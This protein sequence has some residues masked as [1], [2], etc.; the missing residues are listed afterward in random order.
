[1]TGSNL[2]MKQIL[3]SLRNGGVE[4]LDVPLPACTPDKLV[5]RTQASLI[6][7]GTERMLLDFGNSSYLQM[8][9]EHPDRVRQVVDKIVTDGLLPTYEAVTRKLDE[10]LPL[11]YCSAGTVVE[12]GSEIEEFRPGDRVVTNSPHGEYGMV[13]RNLCAAI[14][15]GVPAEHACFAPLGA[16][17]LQ[18]IRLASPTFG[19]KFVVF[20]SGLVGLLTAQLLRANGCEVM[21]VD[22]RDDRLELARGYGADTINSSQ[23]DPERG[24]VAW[25]GGAGADGVIIAASAKDDSILHQ[26]AL[27]CRKRARIVLVGVVDLN[28]RRSD[29]YE[30]ELQFQV[31][32]SYG[33]G[34]YDEKYESGGLDYPLEYVRWTEQRN[35]DAILTALKLR[36]L[37]VSKLVTHRFEFEEAEGAYAKLAEDN[38][39][40]G[41]VLNYA[42]SDDEESSPPV[43]R[44]VRPANDNLRIGMVGAGGFA[45]G[46]L[47]PLLRR[48]PVSLVRVSSRTP[49]RAQFAADKFSFCEAT[50]DPREVLDGA[51]IDAVFIAVEPHLHA[52]FVVEAL[53]SGKHVFVEKP[54]AL[55]ATELAAVADAVAR[56]P[57]QLFSVGF[58]RRF[59]P[60]IGRIREV[61]DGRQEP[62]S[63][64]MTVNP[65]AIAKD[66][67]LLDTNR[68][69][70]RIIGEA[71]H[72]VDLL[73]FIAGSPIISV[74][75]LG[76]GRAAGDPAEN[77]TISLE[78]ADGSIGVI[79]YFANGSKRYPKERLEVFSQGRVLA[80]DNFRTLHGHGFKT[81][82]KFKTL[83]QDK[84][85]RNEIR[86][87]IERASSGGLSP[88]P[89]EQ[90]DNAMRATFSAVQALRESKVIQL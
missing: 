10:P 1:M 65:G 48:E 9:K 67:W 6:S 77:A 19:E 68:G 58:N 85:H 87:F 72:F 76:S 17:A 55:N 59:S 27:V 43:L 63:M 30:K 33:P 50:G 34:R 44:S 18:A 60:H 24:I 7:P 53:E 57:D 16:I 8:A 22:V 13:G 26:A 4:T 29:F 45:K 11:G 71:C 54:P 86:A 74:S 61:L 56:H 15:D 49:H 51:D 83:R 81:F 36:T 42:E 35:F 32:C 39:S 69:G 46:T 21:A 88:T 25:S 40:L 12:V 66:H 31:S 2:Q 73:S 70:G 14:P 75:A 23:G 64:A 20:G 5:V 52:R 37:D 90:I 82:K 80:L 62:L 47:L 28:I 79:N 38:G 3:T 84:G 89:F 41:I 78:F